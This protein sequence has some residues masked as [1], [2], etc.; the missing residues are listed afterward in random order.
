MDVGSY[1][2]WVVVIFL[3]ELGDLGVRS[4]KLMTN[5]STKFIGL[6]GYGLPISGRAPML[7]LTTKE[8]KKYLGTKRVK[9][10]HDCSVEFNKKLNNND[11]S[12]N[13]QASG[14]G[15][16]DAAASI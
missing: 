6:K 9:M 5:N 3:G 1:K 2:F 10:G 14:D 16:S 13:G 8:N 4:M 12:V 7:S 11:D 15:D